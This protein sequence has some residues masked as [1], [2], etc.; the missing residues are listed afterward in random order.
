TPST[1]A[2]ALDR[3]ATTVAAGESTQP[4]RVTLTRAGAATGAVDLTIAGLP[5]GVRASITPTTLSGT[6]TS[7]VVDL[8]VTTTAPAATSSATVTATSGTLSATA[9]LAVTVRRP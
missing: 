3:T 6:A 7:A 1:I 4:V 9:T 2:I 5:A 8:T